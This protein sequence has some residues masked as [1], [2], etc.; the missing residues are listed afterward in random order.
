MTSP[1]EQNA[2]GQAHSWR[3]FAINLCLAGTGLGFAIYTLMQP[4][5]FPGTGK[6]LGAGFFPLVAS[7]G[8]VLFG[9]VAAFNDWPGRDRPT[10][11]GTVEAAAVVE[12]ED[13][14]FN[15]QALV[16][17]VISL[18]FAERVSAEGLLPWAPVYIGAVCL[19]LGARKPVTIFLVTVG[20]TSAFYL[21]YVWGLGIL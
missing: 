19:L 18:I 5:G 9:S 14:P 11:D 4:W 1:T 3:P 6:A 20:L 15:M 2:Q 12:D 10:K 16:L 21:F 7:A 13:T 17:V 8:L